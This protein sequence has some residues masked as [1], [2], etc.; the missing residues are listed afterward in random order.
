LADESGVLQNIAEKPMVAV[1]GEE[2]EKRGE[3]GRY[4]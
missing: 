1:V 3:A 2:N 4:K